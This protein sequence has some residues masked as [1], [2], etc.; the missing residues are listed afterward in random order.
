MNSEQEF[1]ERIENEFD[2]YT[3]R[4]RY[5]EAIGVASKMLASFPNDDRGYYL[6]AFAHHLNDDETSSLKAINQAIGLSPE[7]SYYHVLQGENLLALE[8]SD[9]ALLAFEEALRL[10]HENIEAYCNLYK[11]YM[12]KKNSSKALDFAK[13]AIAIDPS[14]QS[15]QMMVDYH[16]KKRAYDKANEWLKKVLREDAS[17]D[18]FIYQ[19]GIIHLG[20]NQVKESIESFLEALRINPMTGIY[21]DA[22]IEALRREYPIF[23][24]YQ[25]LLNRLEKGKSMLLKIFIFFILPIIIG[26]VITIH[27]DSTIAGSLFLSLYFLGFIFLTILSQPFTNLLLIHHPMVNSVLTIREKVL[28]VWLLLHFLGLFILLIVVF[29][30]QSEFLRSIYMMIYSAI[31]FIG[32]IASTRCKEF[33]NIGLLLIIITG[34]IGFIWQNTQPFFTSLLRFYHFSFALLFIIKF[35][36]FLKGKKEFVDEYEKIYKF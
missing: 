33:V 11:Y 15:M 35:R 18:Y 29:A 2:F 21:K 14:A 24:W 36:R 17:N 9:Q 20:L 19:K 8:K 31:F 12:Y 26:L 28:S 27:F 6:I 3:H 4:K 1:K 22:L 10:D 32:T 16:L 23:N 34:F 5:K 7:K 25:K 30:T 13:Q